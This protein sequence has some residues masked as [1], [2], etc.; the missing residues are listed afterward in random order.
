MTHSGQEIEK[1]TQEERNELG[2]RNWEKEFDEKFLGFIKSE[3]DL[4]RH[5]EI[6]DFLIDKI[7]Q[8]IAQTREE[9]IE[10]IK[11]WTMSE[12]MNVAKLVTALTRL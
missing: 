9:D 5:K 12:K 2:G 6:K 3:H 7:D 4:I 1:M 11:L 8:A 10:T